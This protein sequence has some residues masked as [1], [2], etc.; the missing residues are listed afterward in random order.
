MTHYDMYE[1]DPVTRQRVI[2]VRSESNEGGRSMIENVISELQALVAERD[3]L[4]REVEAWRAAYGDYPTPPRA[5]E[6]VDGPRLVQ[7]AGI[8]AKDPDFHAWCGYSLEEDAANYI[9]GR[10][11]VQSR[12][13]LR[14]DTEAQ[15]RFIRMVQQFEGDKLGL[16][17]F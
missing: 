14:W 3:A 1:R 6:T 5:P 11:R 17:A 7:R 10:C 2:E 13:E 15:R 12:A 16:L 8:L 4:K 9:R